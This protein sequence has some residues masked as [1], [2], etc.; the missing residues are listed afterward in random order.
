MKKL[1]FGFVVLFGLNATASGSVKSGELNKCMDVLN[2]KCVIGD[3]LLKLNF[4]FEF[5]RASKECAGWG[6]CKL[7]VTLEGEPSDFIGMM[8]RNGNLQIEIS[9]KGMDSIAKIFGGKTI[10]IE[11]D[12]TL[13]KEVCYKVGLKEGYTIKAGKYSIVTDASGINSVIF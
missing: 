5:G 13:S 6:I 7:D 12:F 2:E 11:E 1:V 9:K 3:N 8:N 10:I 4:H